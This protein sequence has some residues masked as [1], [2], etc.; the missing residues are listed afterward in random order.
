MTEVVIPV[1]PQS[2]T[3]APAPKPA[4]RPAW[5]P[6]K[7]K[8]AEAFAAAYKELEQKQS[9][10]APAPKP[11]DDAARIAAAGLDMAALSTEFAANE[12]K[13]TPETLAVLKAKGITEA[14]VSNYAAGQKALADQNTQT[15][16]NDVGGEAAYRAVQSWAAANLSKEEVAAYDTAIA[17]GDMVSARGLLRGIT[18]A[19]TTANGRTP[20]LVA[21]AAAP[22]GPDIVP[23]AS[24]AEITQA[25]SDPRYGRDPAYRKMVAQKVAGFHGGVTTRSG[26]QFDSGAN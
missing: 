2:E 7:F 22:R 3:P 10:P 26:S 21:A 4:D 19:Y 25:M 15:I 12:G 18:A 14:D 6:E 5:L 9:A 1:P 11:A 24:Q 16:F 8:D 20:A 23:F 13:L 17:A